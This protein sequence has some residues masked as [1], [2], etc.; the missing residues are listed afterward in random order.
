MKPFEEQK[1]NE[2]IFVYK[3]LYN[4]DIH[5]STAYTISIHITEKGAEMAMELHKHK[6]LKEW[7]EECEEY[8]QATKYPFDHNQW[9]GIEKTELLP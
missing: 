7:E 8:P 3:F 6:I 4:S 5:E 9:W 2:P 1:N